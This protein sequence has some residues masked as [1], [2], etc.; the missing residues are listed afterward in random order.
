MNE[1]LL[2][3]CGILNCSLSSARALIKRM[4]L[5]LRDCTLIGIAIFA[6]CTPVLAGTV[7]KDVPS[8]VDPNAKYLFYMHG[9]AIEQGGP[10]GKVL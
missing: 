9:L 5:F 4:C 8:V 10:S 2:S 3:T 6:V 1:N 7:Q